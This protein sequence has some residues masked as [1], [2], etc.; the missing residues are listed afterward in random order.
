MSA[1]KKRRDWRLTERGQNVVGVLTI[2]TFFLVWGFCGYVEG[3][4]P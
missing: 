1:H 2:I 4:V 3:M